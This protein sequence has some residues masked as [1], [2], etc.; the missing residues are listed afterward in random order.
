VYCT[1]DVPFEASAGGGAKHACWRRRVLAIDIGP[2]VESAPLHRR[3]FRAA[4][5]CAAGQQRAA[6][7]RVALAQINHKFDG[8]VDRWRKGAEE[9]LPIG[10]R[11][12]F[13]CLAWSALWCVVNGVECERLFRD[14]A[15]DQVSRSSI[16]VFDSPRLS[17]RPGGR[18]EPDSIWLHVKADRVFAQLLRRSSKRPSFMRSACVSHG[19]QKQAEPGAAP[20]RGGI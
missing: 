11:L 8:E 19:E 15:E 6:R 1:G 5:D 9:L 2:T 3:G 7:N 20:E 17:S 10:L 18:V 13:A 4:I 12:R 14:A 16:C